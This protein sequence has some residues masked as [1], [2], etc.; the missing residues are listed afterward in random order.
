M[1]AVKVIFENSGKRKEFNVRSAVVKST[2]GWSP[3]GNGNVSNVISEQLWKAV[4]L[5]KVLK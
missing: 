2:I 5:W 4:V 3:S 1:T